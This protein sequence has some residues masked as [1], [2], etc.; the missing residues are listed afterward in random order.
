VVPSFVD[1]FERSLVKKRQLAKREIAREGERE[2][3]RR[4]KCERV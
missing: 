4:E 3:E 2:G 1:K